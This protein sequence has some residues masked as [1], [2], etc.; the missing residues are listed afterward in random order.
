MADKGFDVDTAR[1]GKGLG[2]ASMEERARLV[3]GAIAIHSKPM[4][5]TNIHVSIP[6]PLEQ[7]RAAG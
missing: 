7:Q 4:G 6:L 3:N 1:R 5:G 2:L